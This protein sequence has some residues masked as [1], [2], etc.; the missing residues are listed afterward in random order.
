MSTDTQADETAVSDTGSADTTAD[1]V[2]AVAPAALAK[3][4]EIRAGEDEPD[5]LGLRVEI[6]GVQGP[7]YAYDLSLE[8][9]AEYR[10]GHAVYVVG[11]LTVLIPDASIDGLRGATLDLPVNPAQGGLVI[12][13]PNRPDPLGAAGPLELTG[14][15]P[16]RI[17]QL[18][19][20]RINPALAGHGGF[21]T[22]IGVDGP[23]V[24]LTMGGGCQ[25]CSMSAQTLTDG[26]KRAI[27][28]S[29]PEITEV[30]DATNHEA[31]ENP[32][33]S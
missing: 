26:I 27:L 30:V 18:L 10:D 3:V 7:E 22:L 28:E 1:L 25:G 24:Y 6:I 2:L 23:T 9:V 19:E 5:T 20:Q 29:I 12:R 4:L 21:A 31:G 32:F 17:N 11:E 33:Y 14:E 16:E 15:V 13:N 8:T